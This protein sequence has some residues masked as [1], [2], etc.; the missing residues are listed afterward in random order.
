[1]D[2]A[3]QDSRFGLPPYVLRPK[4]NPTSQRETTSRG[5]KISDIKRKTPVSLKASPPWISEQSGG[6]Q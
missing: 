6:E 4:A 2:D 3:K 1:M 5:Q